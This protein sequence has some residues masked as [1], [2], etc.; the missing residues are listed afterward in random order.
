MI[1]FD[2]I[3]RILLSFTGELRLWMVELGSGCRLGSA[4][5]GGGRGGGVVTAGGGMDSNGGGVAIAAGVDI[6]ELH[7]GRKLGHEDRLASQTISHHPRQMLLL[8]SRKLSR[9]KIFMDCSLV[10]RQRTPHPQILR[11]KPSQIATKP[12]N[13]QKF[14]PS[15]VSRY[16]VCSIHDC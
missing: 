6:L 4:V 12:Q 11:R 2:L 1:V 10:P 13:S 9:E 16:T 3:G 7:G 14:S 8:Y 5:G 15:K